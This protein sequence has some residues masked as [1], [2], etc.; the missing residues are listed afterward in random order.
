[1]NAATFLTMANLI[2]GRLPVF[3]FFFDRAKSKFKINNPSLFSGTIRLDYLYYIANQ[4]STTIIF[5]V[6]Q[7]NEKRNNTPS[8]VT[9]FFPMNFDL[10]LGGY[11]IIN[12]FSSPIKT[13]CFGANADIFLHSSF[14]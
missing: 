5:G 3:F 9:I 13:L 12:I 4:T 8:T 7:S 1:M 10:T 6:Q 2:P 14:K 11:T